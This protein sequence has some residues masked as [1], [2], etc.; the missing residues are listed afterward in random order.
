M[1][2]NYWKTRSQ[3]DDVRRAERL[4]VA[5]DAS[6]REHGTTKFQ[7]KVIDLSV[8]GFR[9]ETSFTLYPGTRVWL[10]IP[11][12]GGLEAAVAWRNKYLYG[13]AFD[14]ALH[15]AVFQHIQSKYAATGIGA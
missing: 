8:T 4:N 7:V 2:Q 1:D 13:F 14:Q 15:P 11:G 9:C 10:T 12:F 3:L 6:I 5:I